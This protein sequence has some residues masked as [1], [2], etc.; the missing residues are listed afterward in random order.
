MAAAWLEP[1][2]E[3][4]GRGWR[5]HHRSNGT[6]NASR[7]SLD[8]SPPARGGETALSPERP[9]GLSPV[10]VQEREAQLLAPSLRRPAGERFTQ[11]ELTAVAALGRPVLG[12]LRPAPRIH[13]RCV[14]QSERLRLCEGCPELVRDE[15]DR[16]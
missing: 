8:R 11:V 14:E 15:P 12:R 7:A 2:D 4:I 3:L 10:P 13:P 1:V 6:A 16:L 9:H 5:S